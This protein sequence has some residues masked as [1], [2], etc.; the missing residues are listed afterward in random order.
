MNKY[1]LLDTRLNGTYIYI[2]TD[3]QDVGVM[4]DRITHVYNEDF[5]NLMTILIKEKEIYK[6]K[7]L[8]SPFNDFVISQLMSLN[9]LEIEVIEKI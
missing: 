3:S 1:F 7:I 2:I 9:N 5:S 8:T 4:I 6:I